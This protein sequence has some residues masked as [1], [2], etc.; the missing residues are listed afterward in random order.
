MDKE[1]IKISIKEIRER[2]AAH[3]SLNKSSEIQSEQEEEKAHRNYYVMTLGKIVS[4]GGAIAIVCIALNVDTTAIRHKAF[5]EITKSGPNSMRITV[6]GNEPTDDSESITRYD[7]W[8]LLS[9]EIQKPSYIPD[10]LNFN[11]LYSLNNDTYTLYVCSYTR[12]LTIKILEPI[13]NYNPNFFDATWTVDSVSDGTAY[14]QHDD[15]YTAIWMHDKYIYMVEWNDFAEIQEIV[16][17]M[18]E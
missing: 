3:K 1:E 15:N 6:T 14:F 10:R 18:H 16:H 13:E 11:E 9:S 2:L 4:I 5:F 17:G 12:G 8:D 7:S